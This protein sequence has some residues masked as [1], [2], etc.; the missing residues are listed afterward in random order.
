MRLQYRRQLG[1]CAITEREV[2]LRYLLD[3]DHDEIEPLADAIYRD[4]R[5][6]KI[7]GWSAADAYCAIVDWLAEQLEGTGGT[8]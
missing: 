7:E 4:Y 3:H 2:A 6:W 8:P 1:R 5:K